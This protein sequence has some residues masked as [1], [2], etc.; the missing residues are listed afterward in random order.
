MNLL[1]KPYL[2]QIPD[3]LDRQLSDRDR[4]AFEQKLSVSK[5]LQH[6]VEQQQSLLRHYKATKILPINTDPEIPEHLTRRVLASIAAEP[7]KRAGRGLAKPLGL[8]AAVAAAALLAVGIWQLFPL[9]QADRVSES[10]LSGETTMAVRQTTAADM[11]SST[12]AALSA[13]GLGGWAI[14][15]LP[16]SDLKTPQQSPDLMN[17]LIKACP[18]S[19][20]NLAEDLSKARTI[21]LASDDASG[22]ILASFDLQ[23]ADSIL[24]EIELSINTCENPVGIEIIKSENLDEVISG[25]DEGLNNLGILAD[26]DSDLWI[27][28]LIGA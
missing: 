23:L 3:Y 9:L 26:S 27:L 20:D 24:N 25:L 17:L 18:E 2:K 11:E 14:V 6:A 8:A 7:A 5:R 12:N 13:D 1:L 28:I 15:S 16:E 10:F 22:Y 21:L 19:A 4:L